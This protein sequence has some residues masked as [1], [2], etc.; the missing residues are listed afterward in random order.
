MKREGTLELEESS[1][2]WYPSP[3]KGLKTGL[4]GD[5]SIPVASK[6]ESDVQT[7]FHLDN[8]LRRDKFYDFF[9]RA[10]ING[11]PRIN[12][13]EL[14]KNLTIKIDELPDSSKISLIFEDLDSKSSLAS[15]GKKNW[16]EQEIIFFVWLVMNYCYLNK[17][18][19]TDMNDKEWEKIAEIFPGRS[20]EQCKLRWQSLLKM[21]LSKAPWTQ[22]EDEILVQV[23]NDKGPK[24]WKEIAI[25]LNKRLGN[26][27]VFRQGKQCRERWINH[28]DPQINRGAWS[29]EEDIKLLE[30]HLQI[31]KRWAEIAKVL[32]SRTENAVKN[33]W[34][35]IIK[36]YRSDFGIDSDSIS[37]TS[38][39]SSTSTSELE[40]KISE[41][42]IS[43]KRKRP[44]ETSPD[45][46]YSPGMQEVPEEEEDDAECSSDVS[47][48][49]TAVKNE[50]QP[51]DTSEKK[52]EEEKERS[53]SDKKNNIVK[54]LGG[55]SKTTK[56]VLLGMVAQE[57]RPQ[58][59]TRMQTE[60]KDI[61]PIFPQQT[62]KTL[63]ENLNLQ[64][65][66]QGANLF[67]LN[68]N[69][70]FGLLQQDALTNQL[71]NL[72]NNNLNGQLGNLGNGL[73][74]A[75]SLNMLN[76][77]NPMNNNPFTTL[78]NEM[79][80]LNIN[81]LKAGS[82]TM[83]GIN[84]LLG[85]NLQQQQ[86]D[87]AAN[88]L[89]I[90]ANN[91][92]FQQNPSNL[93]SLLPN[94][95]NFISEQNMSLPTSLGNLDAANKG[96]LKRQESGKMNTE[97]KEQP[98]HKFTEK[99]IDQLILP[100]TPKTSLQHA[101]VDTE[102][103]HIYFLSPVTNESL[104][105][106]KSRNGFGSN[107][108]F[109]SAI[110]IFGNSPA[111]NSRSWTSPQI[112]PQ[113]F[114][115]SLNQLASLGI[116]RAN[117]SPNLGI[118]ENSPNIDRVFFNQNFNVVE[119]RSNEWTPETTSKT[120]ISILNS[121]TRMVTQMDKNKGL[122]GAGSGFSKRVL[123]DNKSKNNSFSTS[124]SSK[125]DSPSSFLES[126]QRALSFKNG[127]AAKVPVRQLM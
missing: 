9:R 44:N 110:D 112:N 104:N 29:S 61:G 102:T 4:F 20:L 109:N 116:G 125:F 101:I 113:I 3:H 66:M 90:Y 81:L 42:I 5:T 21:N 17:L 91:R 84:S 72:N 60:K 37:T 111:L 14:N 56:D 40:R 124:E 39:H 115:N 10:T 19:Y 2:K 59:N 121:Q 64:N 74:N 120:P 54:R 46:S 69:G 32:K 30:T 34:N 77:L 126:N 93:A 99:P 38:N 49:V 53:Q 36:K 18:T 98:V 27:K 85:Q 45:N 6:Q 114:N 43:Q 89:G 83:G 1:S 68:N 123:G 25:E 95:Q 47:G 22:E 12:I 78:A 33:R 16:S 117:A 122:G 82:P 35:S 11:E 13:E 51:T 88:I 15:R 76:Q 28:L 80:N 94:S 86:N 119:R 50:S 108:N 87:L 57:Q 100:D 67:G 23:I 52:I 75:N 107:N 7:N 92:P 8:K 97:D 58:E 127:E 63:Q 105:L 65:I 96:E 48:D 73:A 31:G 26:L 24:K 106:H 103:G 62:N 41:I 55:K 118:L 71:N 70:G 79:L